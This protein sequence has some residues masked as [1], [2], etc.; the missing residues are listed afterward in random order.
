M[1]VRWGETSWVRILVFVYAINAISEY[2]L[3]ACSVQNAGH[4]SILPGFPAT[5]GLIAARIFLRSGDF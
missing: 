2:R 1:K 3:I 4:R 5:L